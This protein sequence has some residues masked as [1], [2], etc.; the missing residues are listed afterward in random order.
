MVCAKLLFDACSRSGFRAKARWKNLGFGQLHFPGKDLTLA[1]V[2]AQETLSEL[3]EQLASK[4]V[5]QDY[6][7]EEY[8]IARATVFSPAQHMALYRLDLAA[9]DDARWCTCGNEASKNGA[10]RIRRT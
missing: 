3:H 4:N 2:E 9:S 7:E 1:L 10:A 5:Q 8:K 6:T